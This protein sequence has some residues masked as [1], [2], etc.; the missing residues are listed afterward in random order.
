MLCLY[1]VFM[2]IE[3]VIELFD[4]IWLFFIVLVEMMLEDLEVL[5]VYV[6][7]VLLVDFGV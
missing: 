6:F 4:E 3:D 1:L 2:I 7:R 5:M